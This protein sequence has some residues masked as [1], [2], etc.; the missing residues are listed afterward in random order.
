M[1][2]LES[3]NIYHK[4]FN[5][6]FE[7]SPMV[8]LHVNNVDCKYV[9]KL[10]SFEIRGK[11]DDY[12]YFK[13]KKILGLKEEKEDKMK[14]DAVALIEIKTVRNVSSIFEPKLH[15]EMQLQFYLDRFNLSA[16]FVVYVDRRDLKFK[17]FE[18]IF[19]RSIVKELIERARKLHRCLVSGKLPEAEAKGT[20]QCTYCSFRQECVLE[21]NLKGGN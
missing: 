13:I 4:W 11:A 3:G 19:N 18:V 15:H 7:S 16:G 1:L 17:V 21:K 8:E 9:D 5:S 20:W 6:V 2:V 14:Y 12:I 10:D